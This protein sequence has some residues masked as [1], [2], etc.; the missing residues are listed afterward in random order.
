KPGKTSPSQTT[1]KPQTTHAPTS[2]TGGPPKLALEGNKWV[3][4]YQTGKHDLRIT[5]T[6]MRHCIYI[7]KC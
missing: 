3:V 6:N 7:F 4:E 5:E 1:V 2:A